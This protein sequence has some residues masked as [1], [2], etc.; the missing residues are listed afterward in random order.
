MGT[1]I[2]RRC[3]YSLRMLADLWNIERKDCARGKNGT[4]GNDRAGNARA[5]YKDKKRGRDVAASDGVDAARS[6]DRRRRR[7]E[8]RRK[9][10]PEA[11][12]GRP[13]GRGTEHEKADP[14]LCSG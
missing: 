11:A 13:S 8:R 12:G 4:R 10:T 7:R 9:A 1:T 3:R 6:A 2:H 5:Q 14:S